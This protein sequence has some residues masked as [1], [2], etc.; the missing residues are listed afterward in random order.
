MEREYSLTAMVFIILSL[1]YISSSSVVVAARP[2]MMSNDIDT[3]VDHP[4]NWPGFAFPSP[5]FAFPSPGFAFPSPGFNFGQ[6][7]AGSICIF[8]P[9]SA[10]C[11]QARPT[12]NVGPLGG[13]SP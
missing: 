10:G 8:F 12:S 3:N 5:G 11:G 4:Q 6:P 7:G 9:T 1:I 13:G 2:L